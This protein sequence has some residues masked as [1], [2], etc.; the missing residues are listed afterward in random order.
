MEQARALGR[1]AGAKLSTAA[2]D[3]HPNSADSVLVRLRVGRMDRRAPALVLVSRIVLFAVFQVVVAAVLAAAGRPDPW[4][5]SAAWWPITAT[6]AN[7]VTIALL[8]RV[9]RH[10]GL[11][12]ADLYNLGLQRRS[13]LPQ[14][15]GVLAGAIVLG[16]VPGVILGALFFGDAA[17]AAATFVGPL[18]FAVALV[19][20]VAFPVT[21]A[22]AELPAY[23][24]YVMPRLE[25]MWQGRWRALLV[26]ALFLALQQLTLPLVW[27][28]PFLVWRALVFLPLAL[29]LGVIIRG[30]PGFLPY[31]MATQA[32]VQFVA[33]SQVVQ[34][35]LATFAR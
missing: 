8:D 35:S 24:G 2:L 18:P 32:I 7:L 10:E 16:I 19:G 14:L 4:A 17:R 29:F 3:A 12:L 21:A 26:S 22:F 15:I 9:A 28:A 25:A 33:A 13:D 27:D 23:F 1:A 5:R 31:L 11:T 6:A 30:R 20:L 34:V